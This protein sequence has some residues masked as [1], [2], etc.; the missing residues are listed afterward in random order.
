[1]LLKEEFAQSIERLKSSVDAFV[2]TAV[3]KKYTADSTVCLAA[4]NIDTRKSEVP[5]PIFGLF[6]AHKMNC[7]S[8]S[9]TRLCVLNVGTSA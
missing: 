2:Q 4:L 5:R 3:G 6:L 8:Q 7:L 9:T 1:M